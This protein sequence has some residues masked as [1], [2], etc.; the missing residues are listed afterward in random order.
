MRWAGFSG[1]RAKAESARVRSP[2]KASGNAEIG[3]QRLAAETAPQ[4]WTAHSQSWEIEIYG[5]E[6]RNTATSFAVESA[7]LFA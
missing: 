6:G 5:R 4:A 2:A 3:H 7:A 1:A